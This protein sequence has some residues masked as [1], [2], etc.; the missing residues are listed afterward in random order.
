MERFWDPVNRVNDS[1]HRV[2]S[3]SKHKHYLPS[4]NF[5]GFLY[6]LSTQDMLTD[7]PVTTMKADKLRLG[8]IRLA[9]GSTANLLLCPRNLADSLCTNICAQRP[10]TVR[11]CC[12]TRP[13]ELQPQLADWI[14]PGGPQGSLSSPKWIADFI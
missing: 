9:C 6:T 5:L 1:S 4:F 12:L 14:G 8:E 7:F 10:W 3:P 2:P 11:L 13:P